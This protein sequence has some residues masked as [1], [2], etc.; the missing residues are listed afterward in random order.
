MTQHFCLIGD[1]LGHSMSPAIHRALFAH[2]GYDGD[3]ALRPVPQAELSSFFAGEADALCGVNVTIPHK[4]AVIPYLAS[5]DAFAR[6]CGAV[7]VMARENGALRGYNT[8]CSGLLAALAQQGF[9]L[10]GAR[11]L[12]LG[13]GGA[14]LAA[15][16][17]ARRAGAAE[18]FVSA[19][20]AQK[21][22]DFCARTGSAMLTPKDASRVDCLIH[23]TPAGMYPHE[24]ALACDPAAFP[25]LRWVFDMVYNPQQTAL[26]KRCD[27]LG[28]PAASGLAMLVHQ[29]A[30]AHEI[31][32][33]ARFAPAALAQVLTQTQALLCKKRLHDVY[34]RDSI[35]LCG[36]MAAGK[37]TM[38]RA[39]GAL[40]AL[41]VRDADEELARESG[42]TIAQLF[43]EEGEAGFRA[44]E[45]AWCARF[46]QDS[47]PCVLACGGGLPLDA[48][49]LAA[50][51]SRC[52]VVLLDTP[53][54]VLRRRLMGD[55]TRPLL[56]GDDNG[57]RLTRLYDTRMP[58]YRAGADLTVQ[59]ACRTPEE[60]ALRLLTEI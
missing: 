43:A 6:A 1:P 29:A 44:R 2:A 20:D 39:L 57:E 56:R 5:I 48:D 30:H 3:Y 58:C 13:A 51:R 24:G 50:V 54:S 23:A 60:D 21:C 19:R 55:D 11:L 26:T 31:W 33:G 7:N 17:A 18:V 37:S 15:V 40:L 22:A 27:A 41:P 32:Y 16:A 53:L 12:V 52:A 25:A 47:A 14:A 9:S 8:D 46:A 36:F 35:A 28:I 4:Q 34:G 10:A 59:P 38:A 45:R 49:N 42:R